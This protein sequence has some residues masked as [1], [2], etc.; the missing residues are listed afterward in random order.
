MINKGFKYSIFIEKI[1]SSNE[2]LFKK[3]CAFLL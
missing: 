1:E 2:L 3:N